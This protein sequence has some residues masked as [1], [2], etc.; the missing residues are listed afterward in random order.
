MLG[1]DLKIQSKQVNRRFVLIDNRHN[2]NMLDKSE[3][4]PKASTYI[5]D[6]PL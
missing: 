6:T 1:K 2:T 3:L 4:Q 5:R